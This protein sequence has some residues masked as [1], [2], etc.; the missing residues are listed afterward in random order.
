VPGGFAVLSLL[1]ES[2]STAAASASARPIIT[3]SGPVGAASRKRSAILA[4]VQ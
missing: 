2:V 3:K 1:P 4:I